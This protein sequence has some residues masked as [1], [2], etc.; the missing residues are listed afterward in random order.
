MH[1][2]NPNDVAAWWQELQSKDITVRRYTNAPI[3]QVTKFDIEKVLKENLE[4]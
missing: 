1:C 2:T 4:E 3:G